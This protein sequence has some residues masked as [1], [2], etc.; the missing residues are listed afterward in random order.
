MPRNRHTLG[1]NEQLQQGDK[2]RLYSQVQSD[3]EANESG[4]K[5]EVTFDIKESERRHIGENVHEGRS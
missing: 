1:T 2:V 3:D 5:V 4:L